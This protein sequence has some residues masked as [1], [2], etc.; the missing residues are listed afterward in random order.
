V[1]H[2]GDVIRLEV[3][4]LLRLPGQCRALVPANV[5]ELGE[6]M[7]EFKRLDVPPDPDAQP[8]GYAPRVALRVESVGPGGEI[9]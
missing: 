9:G 3:V 4:Q 8:M 1:R 2:D 5:A 6:R 7:G